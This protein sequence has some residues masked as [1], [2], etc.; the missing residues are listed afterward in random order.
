MGTIQFKIFRAS[1]Y[2][3]SSLHNLAPILGVTHDFFTQT[4]S[5]FQM[6]PEKAPSILACTAATRITDS[7]LSLI[8]R[9]VYCVPGS[10]FWT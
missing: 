3:A 9:L 10:L 6:C 5:T 8:S 4:H 1:G 7:H 2:V